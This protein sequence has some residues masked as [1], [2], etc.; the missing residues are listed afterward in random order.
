MAIS[1]T[2]TQTPTSIEKLYKDLMFGSETVEQGL[3]QVIPGQRNKT[4]IVKFSK[5]TCESIQLTIEAEVHI[6]LSQALLIL[7]IKFTV[8]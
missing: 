3:V 1:K 7:L 6:Y 5:E 2:P 8:N 4:Y